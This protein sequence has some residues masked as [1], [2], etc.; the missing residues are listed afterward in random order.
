MQDQSTFAE[1]GVPD[2]LVEVLTRRGIETPFEVQAFTIPDALAG[3]DVAARAPTGS[4]KTIAFGLPLL[5]NLGRAKPRR[6]RGLILA[7]TRELAEQIRRELEPL[8][9]NVG[10]SVLAIYGG[11]GF[12]PQ[13]KPLRK[14][15]DLLVACPGRL[16]DLLSQGELTLDQVDKV[17]IDE[18]DRMADM[19][20]LPVVKELLDLTSSKRQ[21][22]LFSATLD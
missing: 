13:I 18:A 12:G 8:A 2:A 11:V 20:F 16:Q 17:V 22:L 6:P 19:G 7:P 1:L 4:G 14:G 9:E 10:R 15:V 3:R 21:T 5:A